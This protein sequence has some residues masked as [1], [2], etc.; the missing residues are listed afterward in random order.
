MYAN[1]FRSAARCIQVRTRRCLV[2]HSCSRSL[3]SYTR[4]PSTAG[5]LHKTQDA[6]EFLQWFVIISPMSHVLV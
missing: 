5:D 1:L 3:R 4:W 2:L 6:L